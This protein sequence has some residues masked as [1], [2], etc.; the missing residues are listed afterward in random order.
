MRIMITDV[1]LNNLYLFGYMNSLPLTLRLRS[2]C[3]RIVYHNGYH[4]KLTDY[5]SNDLSQKIL[6]SNFYFVYQLVH[7]A[8]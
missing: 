5:L 2:F 6:F 1:D 3:S 4:A 7:T 8:L